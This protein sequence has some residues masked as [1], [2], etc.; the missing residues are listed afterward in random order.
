M[1]TLWLESDWVALRRWYS[2]LVAQASHNNV[3]IINCIRAHCIKPN[4]QL[5]YYKGLFLLF[6][7]RTYFD[8][9]FSLFEVQYF[10]K[11]K[12]LIWGVFRDCIYLRLNLKI[13]IMAWITHIYVW[14]RFEKYFSHHQTSTITKCHFCVNRNFLK[15][16]YIT[17]SVNIFVWITKNLHYLSFFFYSRLKYLLIY[18]N[19]YGA[20]FEQRFSTKDSAL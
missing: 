9:R 11:T 1:S 7:F 4:V 19:V 5:F 2:K 3:R 16:P 13:F 18:K 14:Q 20:I 12:P 8:K 10:G 17:P 15:K 6:F